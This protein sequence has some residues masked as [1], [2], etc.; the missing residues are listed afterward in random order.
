MEMKMRN[1]RIISI[2][3][4]ITLIVIG[5]IIFAKLFYN[6]SQIRVLSNLESTSKESI[7]AF[8]REVRKG[9]EIIAN[10]A[11]L[12]GQNETCDIDEM[13]NDLKPVDKNND[14]KRMGIIT[15]DGF[16]HTTDGNEMYLG[17]RE[18]FKQSM[19]GNVVMSDTLKDR[20]GWDSINVFSAP[21]VF[22][23]GTKCV[24]FATVSSKSF[25]AALPSNIFSGYG[26]SYVIDSRGEYILGAGKNQQMQDFE[27]ISNV[28]KSES[29]HNDKEFNKLKA[30]MKK[31]EAGYIVFDYDKEY[32][33]HYSPI[34]VNNWYM[35]TAVPGKIVKSSMNGLLTLAYI[36]IGI[37]SCAIIILV[38]QISRMRRIGRKDLERIAFMDEATSS[39]NYARFKIEVK[40]LLNENSENLYSIACFNVHK[41][42]YINDLFGYAEGDRALRYVLETIRS[43]LG[44]KEAV[45]RMLADH[46]VVLMISDSKE[47]L[48]NRVEE[49]V[50]NIQK[51]TD[52]NGKH[53][54]IKTTAGVYQ[55]ENMVN[56][57]ETMVDRAKMALNRGNQEVLQ[58]CTFYDDKMR[59]SKIQTKELEDRFEEALAHKEFI[60]YYQP[61]FSIFHQR[62]EGAE[63]LVRWRDPGKG[64]IAPAEFVPVFE[65]NGSIVLLDQYVFEVV[66]SQIRAW[67]D[68]GYEVDPISVNV[69]RLH[70]YRR[71]FVSEYLRIIHSYRVPVEL[72]QLELTETVLLSNEDILKDIMEELH[73]NGI[74]ILMDDFGSGYSSL[75]TLKNIPIDVLKMDKSIINDYE[76]NRKG[77]KIIESVVSLAKELKIKVVAEGVETK[78]QYEF[79]NDIACDYIQGYYCSKPVTVEEYVKFMKKG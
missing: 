16:G 43:S 22:K 42:Q 76:R 59:D 48:K 54:E 18:Y 66:C 15:E 27:N 53:Y 24:M 33:M 4:I 5:G 7:A 38:L 20:D 77:K 41:F 63:A 39:Y 37:C 13:V 45:S 79:L 78:E 10:I 17:D 3:M 61:K 47:S 21:V 34:G 23:D 67:L 69:S 40:R 1:R 51:C 50:A 52:F 71:D 73:R 58:V 72:I 30:D 75:N 55:I 60:V 65:N 19:N 56:E 32:Y 25:E 70:L 29:N 57:I 44:E 68:Q 9:K 74:W 8:Q 64:L 2:V 28:L 26:Y 46:F 35:L 12:L 62:F 49:I 11:I 14:F 36:F 6:S 31:E